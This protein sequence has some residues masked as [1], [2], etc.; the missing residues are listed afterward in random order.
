MSILE[1]ILSNSPEE[2]LRQEERERY[3]DGVRNHVDV[4]LRHFLAYSY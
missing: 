3:E 1:H 4:D 2:A